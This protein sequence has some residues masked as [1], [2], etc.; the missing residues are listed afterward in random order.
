MET[1]YEGIADN[2]AFNLFESIQDSTMEYT[3]RGSF[4]TKITDTILSLT[5]SN[6]QNDQVEKK[7]RKR[8]FFIIVEGLQ[9]VTRHQS[10]DDSDELAGY[11]GLFVVQ[12]KPDGY[13]ITTGNL[14]KTSH[15]DTI[16][17]TTRMNRSL[18]VV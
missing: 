9:N 10:S 5:E 18:F 17:N 11:P 12:Y 6:L 15:K 4:T 13:Y 14:I 3:Y 2:L 8:V 7:I 1:I 16:K